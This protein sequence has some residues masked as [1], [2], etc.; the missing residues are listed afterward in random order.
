MSDPVTVLTAED[1]VNLVTPTRLIRLKESH[2]ALRAQLVAQTAETERLKAFAA[3]HWWQS[4]PL[5]DTG[6]WNT[7]C[8]FCGVEDNGQNSGDTCPART[9]DK[10][11]AALTALTARHEAT[12]NWL[13]ECESDAVKHHNRSPLPGATR[14]WWSGRVDTFRDVLA[15]LSGG[16]RNA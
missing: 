9:V 3:P 13:K 10:I 6:D 15:R 14:S 8:G 4:C 1:I 11:Q 7:L 16:E 5:A 2:E 12:V